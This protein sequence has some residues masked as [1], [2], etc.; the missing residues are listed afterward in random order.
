VQVLLAKAD[1]LLVATIELQELREQHTSL[2]ASAAQLQEQLQA[3]TEELSETRCGCVGGG[4]G[5]MVLCCPAQASPAC[6]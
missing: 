6:L 4:R 1:Q 2:Q 3:A 5:M